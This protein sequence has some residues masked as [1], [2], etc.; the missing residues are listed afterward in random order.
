MIACNE[1]A[2]HNPPPRTTALP[3]LQFL[4]RRSKSERL[5]FTQ[6]EMFAYV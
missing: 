3:E 4:W 5:V 6:P 1:H 2:K